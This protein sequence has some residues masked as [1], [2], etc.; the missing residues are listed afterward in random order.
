MTAQ[1]MLGV[2]IPTELKSEVREQIKKCLI[3][4]G[5]FTHV[6]S[7]N[8]ENIVI[9]QENE[10]FLRILN[11]AEVRIIDGIG[12]VKAAQTLNIP[13]GDRYSGVDLMSDLLNDPTI[14]PLR[15]LFI[16]GK[17]NL[18]EEL[19]D[20][21]QANQAQIHNDNEYRGI[22]GFEDITRPKETEEARIR[23]IVLDYMPHLVFVAFGSPYQ[24]LWIDEHK[25]YFEAAVCMGVG[26][27]FDFLSGRVSRAP[28]V[29]RGIGLEWLYR[30]IRQ[31]WRIR[32]QLRLLK[33]VYLVMKKKLSSS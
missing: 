29:V 19:A 22:Q 31:P 6:V 10:S 21:Y 16:G 23:S 15:V 18:A 14:S 2:V 26:G 27:G 28:R 30:L 12:I 20:C 13:V 4:H 32:R 8:P 11:E 25:H 1:K 17:G 7:L 33:F 3:S 5:K 24:E 9:A